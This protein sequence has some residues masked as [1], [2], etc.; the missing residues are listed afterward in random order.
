[1]N[2]SHETIGFDDTRGSDLQQSHRDNNSEICSCAAPERRQPWSF[3]R[4]T[5]SKHLGASIRISFGER[6]GLVPDGV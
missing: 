5:P 4:L 6:I 2:S 1:M 3:A